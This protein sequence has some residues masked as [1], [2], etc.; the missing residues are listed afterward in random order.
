MDP[1]GSDHE[2]IRARRTITKNYVDS[3]RQLT[4]RLHGG[5]KT[6]RDAYAPEQ[7]VVELTAREAQAGADR[8][9]EL[10]QLD[11][12]QVA[13]RVVQNPLAGHPDRPSE[14]VVCKTQYPEG[15]DAIAREV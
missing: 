1:V 14:H 9:P 5:A 11:L 8:I 10:C 13:S 12:R 3:A 2:V 6:D 7:D 15:A 4:E